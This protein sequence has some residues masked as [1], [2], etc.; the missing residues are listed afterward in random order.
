MEEKTLVPI[1]SLIIEPTLASI[2]QPLSDDQIYAL[3]ESIKTYG[4]TSPVPVWGNIPVDLINVYNICK[5]LRYSE[6]WVKP[7]EFKNLAEAAKFRIDLHRNRR[8]MNT[9]TEIEAFLKL[10]EGKMAAQ[11]RQNQL[12]GA[13]KGGL[14]N[15]CQTDDEGMQEI[16]GESAETVWVNHEIAYLANTNHFYVS[17]VRSLLKDPKRYAQQIKELRE[18]T[19]TIG[20]LI[21]KKKH[22]KPIN[23]LPEENNAME[24]T[25]AETL[26]DWEHRVSYPVLKEK[27]HDI[28]TST[29]DV[30]TIFTVSKS[31][32]ETSDIVGLTAFIAKCWEYAF[33]IGFIIGNGH[34]EDS[35]EECFDTRTKLVKSTLLNLLKEHNLSDKDT[36]KPE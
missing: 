35:V 9:F 28:E 30:D 21:P 26:E 5:R 11:A 29:A 32:V 19:R 33:R 3:E 4:L 18:G 6:I 36:T 25:P 10:F 31:Y 17:F 24:H 22:I 7:L 1:D 15:G 34:T 14:S 20:S 12:E 2:L 27:N 13:R 23:P 8:Q 16:S